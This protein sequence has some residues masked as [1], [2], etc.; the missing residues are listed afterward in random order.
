MTKENKNNKSSEHVHIFSWP[1][2]EK[3]EKV[4]HTLHGMC[5]CGNHN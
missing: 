1:S 4:I 3:P 2:K 5:Q